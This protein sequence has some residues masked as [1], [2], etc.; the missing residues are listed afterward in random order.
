LARCAAAST[1]GMSLAW[2]RSS[3]QWRAAPPKP[4]QETDSGTGSGSGPVNPNPNPT[5][6]LSLPCSA[7][8][9]ERSLFLWNNEYIVSLV[10]QQ[11]GAVLPLVFAALER[12][13]ASHWNP[14]VHGL[15]C[16]V[17]KMFQDMDEQLYEECRLRYEAEEVRARGRVARRGVA[18]QRMPSAAALQAE[19]PVSL[20]V[21]SE[22]QE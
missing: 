5:L 16:N 7:Q 9:A 21:L 11:R 18:R 1:F 12:N 13:A 10:A 4:C 2:L 3:A 19:V 6:L 20:R 17:R 15:T 8:V 22:I 14:A